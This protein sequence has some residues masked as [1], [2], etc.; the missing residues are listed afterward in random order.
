MLLAK[1]F[2]KGS[3]SAAISH[4][5]NNLTAKRFAFFFTLQPLNLVHSSKVSANAAFKAVFSVGS[6]F[7]ILYF[8]KIITSHSMIH[9]LMYEAFWVHFFLSNERFKIFFCR[10]KDSE[11]FFSMFSYGCYILSTDF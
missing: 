5:F 7:Y 1:C 4:S 3:N 2:S 8:R 9:V 6:A 11:S 10:T